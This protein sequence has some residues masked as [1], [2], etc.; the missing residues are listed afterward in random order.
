M[1]EIVI[2]MILGV[3]AGAG[4]TYLYMGQVM[5]EALKWAGAEFVR[6]CEENYELKDRLG[7]QI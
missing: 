6:V 3:A 5:I 1:N 2:A 4:L 7:D